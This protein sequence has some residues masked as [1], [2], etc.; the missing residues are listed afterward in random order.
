MLPGRLEYCQGD[1]TMLPG[2]LCNT[3]KETVQCCRNTVQYCQRDCA[4]LLGRLCNTAGETV[5][6][7][8]GGCAVFPKG[9][10]NA[11]R[12][13]CTNSPAGFHS[14][15]SSI[16][17]SPCQHRT[18]SWAALQSTGQH[19]SHHGSIAHSPQWYCSL[20]GSTAVLLEVLHRFPSSIA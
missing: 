12:E 7:C 20:L 3:G 17:Q 2:K 11:A 10:W 9:L 1:Y 19:C 4:M 14:L 16:V 13:N 18:V 15:S 5:R 6:S 8:L